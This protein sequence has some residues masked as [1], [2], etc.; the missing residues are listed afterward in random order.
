MRMEK[1]QHV[2]LKV[3]LC[4]TQ[5]LLQVK[6]KHHVAFINCTLGLSRQSDA[7]PNVRGTQSCCHCLANVRAQSDRIESRMISNDVFCTSTFCATSVPCRSLSSS[8]CQNMGRYS[9]GG[10]VLK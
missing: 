4:V 6:S 5:I 7:D 1:W 9:R 8:N 2:C 3:F 10:N